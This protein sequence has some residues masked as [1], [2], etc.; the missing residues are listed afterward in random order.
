MSIMK[1]KS[2]F[3]SGVGLSVMLLVALVGCSDSTSDE[4]V[5]PMAS[6]SEIV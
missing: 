5:S 2:W 1:G 6:S 4:A 3:F